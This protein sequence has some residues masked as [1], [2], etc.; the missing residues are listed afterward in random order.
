MKGFINERLARYRSAVNSLFVPPAFNDQEESV[1]ASLLVQFLIPLVVFSPFFAVLAIVSVPLYASRWLVLLSVSWLA[2]T[3][4]LT[5]IHRH[6]PR[7]AAAVTLSEFWLMITFFSAT[8]GGIRAPIIAAYLVLVLGAGLLLGAKAGYATALI[9]VLT[10]SAFVYSDIVI[11]F[12]KNPL[13]KNDSMILAVSV[14][15]ALIV[16]M[17]QHVASHNFRNA[18]KRADRELAERKHTELSLR[19]SEER[20]SRLSQATFEGIIVTENGIIVDANDQAVAMFGGTAG[21]I[22]GKDIEDLV[23]PAVTSSELRRI[24]LSLEETEEHQA[25]RKDGTTFPVETRGRSLSIDGHDIRLT[26]I[27]DITERRQAEL[28]QNAVYR[29]S[30]APDQSG[31]LDVLYRTVHEVIRTVMP[32]NNFYIALFDEKEDVV[33]FPYFVDEVDTDFPPQKS[34]RGLTEYVIRTGK[35]LICD[36]ETDRK[37]TER[38]EIELVGTPSAV[39][40]GV[41]LKIEGNTLGVMAVQ[42]YANPNAYGERDL[43]MLEFVSEQVARAI[44]KKRADD[45]AQ[46]ERILLRTLVD[47][48]PTP[49]CVKNRLHQRTLVN[50]SYVGRV[51]LGPTRPDLNFRGGL[52][53]MTDFDMYPPEIAGE[54][55]V[56]DERVIRDGELVLDREDFQVDSNG[57]PHWELVSKIPMYDEKGKVIGLVSI[58]TDITQSKKAQEELRQLNA[59]N[60]MLIQTLPFGIGIVDEDGKILFMSERLKSIV[61]ADSVGERCWEVYRDDKSQ[62]DGCPLLN[63]IGIGESKSIEASGMLNGRTVLINHTGLRYNGHNAMLE[64]LEDITEYKKLQEQFLQSQKLEGLGNIAAGIAHDFNNILGVILGYAEMLH[65]FDPTSEQAARGLE[66]IASSA[67]RGKTLV[68]QLLT[69]ARKTETAFEAVQLNEVVR[70]TDILLN[71]TFPKTIRID[72]RLCHD[73]PPITADPNQLHQVLLNIC[74]N[75]RDAM[76]EGGTISISTAVLPRDKVASKHFDGDAS[77]YVR[78]EISDTGIGMDEKTKAH[79]FEPFFSTKEIGKGTGLGLSVVYG[80]IESHNGFVE[81]S[82]KPGKGTRFSIYF[83]ASETEELLLPHEEED[84]TEVPGGSETVLVIED[85]ESLLEIVSAILTSSGYEVIS[86]QDGE[87]GLSE[88]RK[89]RKRIAAVISDLGLPGL[90]GEEVVEGIRKIDPGMNMIIASGYISPDAKERLERLGVKS[91]VQKPYSL[92]EVLETIRKAIDERVCRTEK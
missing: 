11:R 79:I 76:P 18:L 91:F 77:R 57:L 33:T 56:D 85:E 80:I 90:G 67:R 89:N 37:L 42:H 66:A 2:I 65:D 32:A 43:R 36:Q 47:N 92:R 54:Q 45:A 83:P 69:F 6:R 46:R 82:S 73:L 14:F 51:R 4:G 13:E 20:Y 24:T 38:G 64:V 71:A 88:F 34:G 9:C 29:I 3:S 75:A 40:L 41:P 87:E 26:M 21:D 49:I 23:K 48:L 86:A 58:A 62:C 35:S 19:L 70:E 17:F 16:A 5:L 25:I 22:V 63:H 78:L 61:G 8:A 52:I 84:E 10:E 7:T 55:F 30:Q 74:V 27:R 81:V 68:S 60:E 72:T 28:L 1:I 39:W 59:F 44:E 53:G 15:L 12:P 50:P 31:N